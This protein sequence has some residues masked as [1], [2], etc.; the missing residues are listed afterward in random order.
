MSAG[1]AVTPVG[2]AGMAVESV[3]VPFATPTTVTPSDWYAW[4]HT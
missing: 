1:V 2:A 3:S 4:T